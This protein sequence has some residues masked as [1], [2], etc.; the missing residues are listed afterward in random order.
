[1]NEL[2]QSIMEIEVY[3]FTLLENVLSSEDAAEMREALI[4]CER[5]VGTEHRHRGAAR[6]VSNLPVLDRVFH[7]CIDH[8]RVLPILEHFLDRSLILGSLNSRIV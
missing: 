6:H 2:Q 5:E 4:R 1:M 3:G 8:P 7:P